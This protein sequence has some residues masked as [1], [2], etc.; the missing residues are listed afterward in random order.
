MSR[1]PELPLVDVGPLLDGT[2]PDGVA[3]ALDDA[4]RRFGFVRVTGHGADPRPLLHLAAEFFAQPD[5][6]KSAIAMAL[7]GRAWR[8]W[9]PVGAELTSGI[10]DGKEGIYFGEDLP[11]TDRRVAGGVAL[12]GA[13]L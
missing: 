11:P 10:P 12:H 3:A 8:G 2:A 5:E 7:A 13:N 6:R 9:F 1:T 4:C